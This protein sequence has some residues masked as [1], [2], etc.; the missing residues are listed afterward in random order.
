MNDIDYTSNNYFSE[1]NSMIK[2]NYT[3]S[4][5]FKAGAEIRNNNL[6]FRLGAL[7]ST[8]P[9]SK[10]LNLADA[11]DQAR[12]GITAGFGIKEERYFVDFAFA[13]TQTGYYYQPYTLNNQE[14]SGITSKQKDNRLLITIGYVL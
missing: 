6:R 5:N 10:N 13:H 4:H 12:K 3:S 8:S 14:V 2:S 1:V 7:Y 11:I 9:F